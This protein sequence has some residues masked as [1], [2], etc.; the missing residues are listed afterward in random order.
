VIRDGHLYI[1]GRLKDLIIIAG[2]NHH[3]EDIERT[4]ERSDARLAGG[5]CTSFPVVVDGQEQ[6]V[7]AVELERYSWTRINRG[8]EPGK[9]TIRRR[10]I[11]IKSPG[12]MHGESTEA[13]RELGGKIRE[14][15]AW[16]HGIRVHDIVLLPPGALPRATSGKIRRHRCR[17]AYLNGDFYWLIYGRRPRAVRISAASGVKAQ[18]LL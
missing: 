5:C 17:E 6:L 7:L 13:A 16:T 1:V 14:A 8:R 3:P 18:G 9:S 2:R 12:W 4:V 11:R 10:Q 15:V